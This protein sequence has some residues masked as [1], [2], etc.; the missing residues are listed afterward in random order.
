VHSLDVRIEVTG[1]NS[2]ARFRSARMPVGAVLQ[3]RHR[4]SRHIKIALASASALPNTPIRIGSLVTERSAAHSRNL[5]VEA[6]AN[7]SGIRVSLAR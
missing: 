7:D 2:R 3:H 5:R 6:F 4:T 1:R